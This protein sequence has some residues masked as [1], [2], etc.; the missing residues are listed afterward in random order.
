MGYP[1]WVSLMHHRGMNRVHIE[2]DSLLVVRLIREGCSSLQLSHSLVVDIQNKLKS[3]REYF[4]SHTHR[5]A[6][7]MAEV[8][9]EL[10]C[11][12]QDFHYFTTF[13]FVTVSWGFDW[14]CIPSRFQSVLALFAGVTPSGHKKKGSRTLILAHVPIN[15]A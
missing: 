5:K 4:F 3:L 11:C 2:S 12:L 6:N 9:T 10:G 1:N 8:W 7:Q 14:D 13:Y 15:W